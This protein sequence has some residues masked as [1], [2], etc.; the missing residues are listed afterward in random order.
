MPYPLAGFEAR[1]LAALVAPVTVT[2][3]AALGEMMS[4]ISTDNL[5]HD[6]THTFDIFERL[7]LNTCHQRFPHWFPHDSS[8]GDPPTIN[9]FHG[10]R[11][12]SNSSGL[13]SNLGSS[14]LPT[15]RTGHAL[16]SALGAIAGSA[17]V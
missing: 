5:Q 8:Q 10:P 6:P 16:N 11:F 9:T 12:G 14:Q 17:L 1:P 4:V 13:R 15:V 3:E 2:F 7:T